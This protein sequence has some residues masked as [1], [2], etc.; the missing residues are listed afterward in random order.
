MKMMKKEDPNAP[1]SSLDENYEEE[2]DDDTSSSGEE[3]SHD[4]GRSGAN[5]YPWIILTETA[6]VHVTRREVSV[7]AIMFVFLRDLIV[8]LKSTMNLARTT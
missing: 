4:E 5:H 3:S 2:E 8:S 1:D 7:C 6:C